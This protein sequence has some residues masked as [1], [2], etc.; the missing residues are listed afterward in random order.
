MLHRLSLVAKNGGY[1]FLQYIGTLP[2]P[3]IEPVS[4]AL[5]GNFLSTVPPGS[6]KRVDVIVLLLVVLPLGEGNGNLLH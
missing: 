2:G 4:P 1:S 3:G 5:A 6:S